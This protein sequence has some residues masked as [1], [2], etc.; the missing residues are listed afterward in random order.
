MVLD[1]PPCVVDASEDKAVVGELPVDELPCEI[2]EELTAG[3][4]DTW[5]LVAAELAPCEL[6]AGE[7]VV[8]EL[9][10]EELAVGELTAGEP[11]AEELEVTELAAGEPTTVLVALDRLAVDEPVLLVV[12]ELAAGELASFVTGELPTRVPAD[13]ADGLATDESA[14]VSVG[15]TVE[16]ALVENDGE[17]P[18]GMPVGFPESTGVGIPVEVGIVEF[19]ETDPEGVPDGPDVDGL[20]L[21]TAKVT[22][23]QL[24]GAL[25]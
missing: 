11:A 9:E 20:P 7:L 8:T 18:A 19:V 12:R 13:V 24:A 15:E 25:P 21:L 23:L 6:A 1:D 22:A 10:V 5:E 17:L 2:G 3:P 14:I 16:G 4:L